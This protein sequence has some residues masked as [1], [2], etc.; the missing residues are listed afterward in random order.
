MNNFKSNTILCSITDIVF[1]RINAHHSVYSKH[2]NSLCWNKGFQHLETVSLCLV[3]KFWWSKNSQ[4][5]GKNE[6]VRKVF[7]RTEMK[8]E[9]TEHFR[10][11][12]FY[13]VSILFSEKRT[14]CGNR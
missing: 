1:P 2:V 13:F 3:T 9:I 14:R 7:N 12:D 4:L 6:I 11:V 8:H 10:K 5:R